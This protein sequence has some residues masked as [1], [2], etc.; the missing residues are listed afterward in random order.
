M[1]KVL[2]GEDKPQKSVQVIRIQKKCDIVFLSCK[3]AVMVLDTPAWPA[4]GAVA[5]KTTTTL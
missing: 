5:V 2:L 1:M 4:L 3:E